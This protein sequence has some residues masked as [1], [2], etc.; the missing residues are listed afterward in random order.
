MNLNE[1]NTDI[2][3]HKKIVPSQLSEIINLT[4]PFYFAYNKMQKN[5]SKIEHDNYNLTNTEVDALVTILALRDEKK[6]ISPKK[7]SEKLIFSSA[8]ITKVLKKL[9][10]R[11]LIIRL[12]NKFDKRSKLV[13]ITPI[14]EEICR[15]VF[16]DILT[17]ENSCFSVL[18]D[19][20]K[21]IFQT[22][23]VKILKN[24]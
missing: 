1:L 23:F 11:K 15:E 17:Y 21:E 18:S 12:D 9:E 10:D 24:I 6:T 8:A 13:K 16:K 2:I 7:L 4:F 22:L 20:E 5:I 14:G 19:D 3:A